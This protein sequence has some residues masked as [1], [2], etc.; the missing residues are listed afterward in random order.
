MTKTITLLFI[1]A[2][3]AATSLAAP[4]PQQPAPP[5]D[6]STQVPAAKPGDVDSID[7][8]MAAIYNVISG[9]PGKRDWDRFRSLFVPGGKLTSTTR[10]PNASATDAIPVRLLT[11]EDYVNRVG[12][13]FTTH[14]FFERAVV[15]KVQ[16]FG[17][18]AQVFS[19]YESRHT[20]DE[21]PFTRGINSMQLLYDGKRWY[22]LSI[23]WDEESAT[24]P[25]PADMAKP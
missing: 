23:L 22:V 24:N 14:G 1:V 21:K 20:P 11:V 10:P 15:N 25:L 17:N 6:L 8:V 5:P 3:L 18:I 12:D 19:S 4:K 9:P 2:V 16:R 13:Y 7:H